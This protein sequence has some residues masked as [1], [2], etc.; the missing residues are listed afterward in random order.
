MSFLH[1]MRNQKKGWHARKPINMSV[2]KWFF[3]TFIYHRFHI[4]TYSLNIR[5]CESKLY[6]LLT[7]Y[8]NISYKLS[9]WWFSFYFM[10]DGQ[11]TR[12]AYINHHMSTCVLIPYQIDVRTWKQSKRFT[13]V[14]ISLEHLCIVF[15]NNIACYYTI[16]FKIT[17]YFW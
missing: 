1:V 16:V 2:I 15:K 6:C 7:K 5:F 11:V 13:S 9:I 3:E 14:F 4:R 12:Y 8:F 17:Y 10:I